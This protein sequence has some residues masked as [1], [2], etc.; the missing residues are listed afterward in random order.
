M[1]AQVEQDRSTSPS[2]SQAGN[3]LL[4]VRPAGMSP[5]LRRGTVK[6]THGVSL[7]H[8]YHT[9]QLDYDYLETSRRG[10]TTKWATLDYERYH[11]AIG[12]LRPA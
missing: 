8:G 11:E 10:G 6:I 3:D 7:P 12:D 2:R 9:R 1:Q 5:K 4:S